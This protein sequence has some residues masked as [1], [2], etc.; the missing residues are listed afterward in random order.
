VGRLSFERRIYTFCNSATS[1]FT[2]FARVVLSG[3]R[4]STDSTA[5]DTI[6]RNAASSSA[7]SVC[8]RIACCIPSYRCHAEECLQWHDID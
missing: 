2:T 3:E 8:Q 1:S 4:L 5:E 6:A 7:T